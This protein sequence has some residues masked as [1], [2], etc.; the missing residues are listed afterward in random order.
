VTTR[1]DDFR[2]LYRAERIANQ[3]QWYRDRSAEYRAAHN[4]AILVRNGLL[5]VAAVCGVVGVA[6]VGEAT[7]SV[8]GL[9]AA[10]LA[11]LATVVTGFE[12]LVDFDAVRKLY[13]DAAANLDLVDIDW[14]AASSAELPELVERVE[15]VLESENGRW[16][17]LLRASASATAPAEEA[18]QAGAG[19]PEQ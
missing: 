8:L 11:A 10:L 1:D 4:Q 14:D 5:W 17:Q 9:S 3:L 16:G 13:D 6:P 12:T 15:G 19:L 2:R 7:R 18:G